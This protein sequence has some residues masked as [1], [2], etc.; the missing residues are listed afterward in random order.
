MDLAVDKWFNRNIPL[1][2]WRKEQ[3]IERIKKQNPDVFGVAELL[4]WQERYISE[5]FSDYHKVMFPKWTDAVLYARKDKYDKL[6][7]GHFFLS[8]TPEKNFTRDYGNFMP[9]LA[10]WMRVRI[11]ETGRELLLLS[12]HF[13]GM[14]SSRQ[15]SVFIV[16][17]FI[18]KKFPS[19]PSVMAADLNMAFDG[20]GWQNALSRN[21]RSSFLESGI[22]EKT[23]THH[24]RMVDHIILIN[25]PNIKVKGFQRTRRE[26]GDILLSD[27]HMVHADLEVH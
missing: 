11:K 5:N 10:V 3:V 14:K 7:E 2:H 12:S 18:K 19:L 26:A 1:W 20:D 6:E 15:Q 25:A 23:P 9:R 17:D 4:P 24:G 13:D 21:W 27:H 8:A 16:D 22:K